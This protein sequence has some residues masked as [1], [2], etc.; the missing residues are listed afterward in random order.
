MLSDCSSAQVQPLC[1]KLSAA[2]EPHVLLGL[3]S[4][5][6]N[7]QGLL[8][9][10]LVF[11]PGARVLQSAHYKS[12]GKSDSVDKCLNWSRYFLEVVLSVCHERLYFQILILE[13]W[14]FINQLVANWQ[15][16]T[17]K[18]QQLLLLLQ[19]HNPPPH[20]PREEQ[21]QFFLTCQSGWYLAS[22]RHKHYVTHIILLLTKIKPYDVSVSVPEKLVD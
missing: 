13:Y 18:Q 20:H 1:M 15:F 7:P 10:C 17:N 14:I 11:S 8:C 16:K 6:K 9:K 22:Q 2:Q 3:T 4:D 19:T 5:W 21:H 12:Y